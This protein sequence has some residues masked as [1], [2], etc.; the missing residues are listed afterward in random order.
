MIPQGSAICRL[1]ARVAMDSP[2]LLE[3]VESPTPPRRPAL[4]VPMALASM[5]PLADYMSVR[6]HSAS[7]IFWHSVK[8]PTA[9][10][11]EAKLAMRKAGSIAR[12]KVHPD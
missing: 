9:L 7:S 6:F 12:L 4:K 2:T 5:P 3:Y 10:S 11:V 1:V 8:S